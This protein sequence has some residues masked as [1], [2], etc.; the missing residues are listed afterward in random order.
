M[1]TLRIDDSGPPI[2]EARLQLFESEVGYGLP[3]GY[4]S[5]L[6]RHNGGRPVP[7]IMPTPRFP[8][9]A[10]STVQV[11]YGLDTELECEE[12]MWSY[13]LWIEDCP[14]NLLPIACDDGDNQFCV[15][16][17]GSDLGNVYYWDYYREV[18][19]VSTRYPWTYL[20]ANSFEEF[21][22]SIREA[23]PD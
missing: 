7:N 22:E 17:A 5:F 12:L 2:T 3:K 1:M 16:L 18:H 20:I 19:A 6:L 11:F 10:E 14:K 13:R 4:R 23:P 21:L 15:S 9:S 8:G